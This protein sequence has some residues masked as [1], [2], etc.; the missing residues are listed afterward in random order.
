MTML[1]KTRRFGDGSL[2][3]S[4]DTLTAAQSL[5][6]NEGHFPQGGR[7]ASQWAWL[8]MAITQLTPPQRVRVS[9]WTGECAGGEKTGIWIINNSSSL[10]LP[11]IRMAALW[12][13]RRLMQTWN[14]G[15]LILSQKSQ[16]LFAQREKLC[17][18]IFRWE[19]AKRCPGRWLTCLSTGRLLFKF[20]WLVQKRKVSEWGFHH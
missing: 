19:M 1:F 12:F 4:S 7:K 6:S 18:N 15:N 20:F 14:P 17:H 5:A 10:S 11:A 2:P 8:C 9:L 3:E 13:R 16:A